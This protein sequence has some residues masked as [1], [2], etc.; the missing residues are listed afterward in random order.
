MN[1]IG[2]RMLGANWTYAANDACALAE[3]E[4]RIAQAG[5]REGTL[6]YSELVKGVEF[7]L[8]NILSGKP[9]EIDVHNWTSL[10][11]AVIG[12]FL[13]W[14][15]TCSY[16]NHGFMASALAVSSQTQMPSDLFYNWMY[17]IGA[18]KSNNEISQMAFWTEQLNKAYTYYKHH[19]SVL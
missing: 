5:R 1:T 19:N 8:P 11:R 6:T 2:K 10:D 9:F 4:E 16:T 15:S 18:L 14:I 17:E 13:G 12:E 7:R 3:L